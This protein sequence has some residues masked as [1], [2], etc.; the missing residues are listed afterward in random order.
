MRR[1][2]QAVAAAMVFVAAAVSAPVALAADHG[3]GSKPGLQKRVDNAT[4]PAP[5]AETDPWEESK[6]HVAWAVPQPELDEPTFGGGGVWYEPGFGMVELACRTNYYV[7]YWETVWSFKVSYST[8]Y[9][10]SYEL[11]GTLLG[12]R[13]TTLA[14]GD[15]S[16]PTGS[17][18]HSASA[19]GTALYSG[20]DAVNLRLGSNNYSASCVS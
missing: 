12:G 1:S 3:P 14:S 13:V 4:V 10:L 20:F 17:Q 16:Q 2:V 8:S 7:F 19:S 18:F 11:T 5:P 15:T 9:R 6:G